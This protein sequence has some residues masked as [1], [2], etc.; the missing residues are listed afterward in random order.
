MTV[1]DMMTTPK[2]LTDAKTY[3]TDV[4]LKTDHYAPLLADT[5][6][7]AIWLNAKTMAELRPAMEK[8]YYDPTKYDSYLQQLGIKYPT[9]TPQ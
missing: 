2:L 7:P 1:L 9:V 8:F 3:F 5:D 4:Q 6:K